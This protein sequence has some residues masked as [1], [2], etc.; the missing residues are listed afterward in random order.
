[1]KEPIIINVSKQELLS[2]SSI[3]RFA[4][5]IKNILRNI[6]SLD[7]Y[8]AIIREEEETDQKYIVKGSKKDVIAFADTL[9]KEKQYAKDYMEHGLGSSELSD[10][11]LELEKSIHNFEK[12]TGVKWPVG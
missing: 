11:K 7:A 1:M 3:A 9:E 6:L 5:Q 12:T 4:A 8:R 2:E 10:T